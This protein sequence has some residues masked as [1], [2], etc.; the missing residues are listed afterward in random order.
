MTALYRNGNSFLILLDMPSFTYTFYGA[1]RRM[2][3]N[4][5]L[6]KQKK[7]NLVTSLEFR[8]IFHEVLTRFRGVAERNGDLLGRRRSGPAVRSAMVP[9]DAQQ[10]PR[11][12]LAHVQSARVAE[13]PVVHGK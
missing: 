6:E 11:G 10:T 3:F 9:K 2:C 4:P 1:P 7:K 5:L 8:R 13:L 12:H